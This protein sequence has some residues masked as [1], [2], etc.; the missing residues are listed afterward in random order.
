MGDKINRDILGARQAGFRLAV[1]IRHVYD[2][3]EPDEGAVPDAVITRMDELLPLLERELEKDRKMASALAAR[4]IK[5]LFFDAG[6]ILYQRA[7]PDAHFRIFLDAHPATPQKHF[8]EKSKALKELAFIGAL[9]RRQYHTRL[10]SLHG[11]EDPALVEEGIAALEQDELVVEIMPGVP[12]TLQTLKKC[13]FLLGIITDTALPNYIKLEWFR[14]AGFG[15]VWD[16]F[17]S[18]RESGV[19]KPAAS[20]YQRGL[21]QIG[22]PANQCVF[23]GHRD[24]ELEGARAMGMVTVAYNYDAEAKADF[25]IRD[26]A[27]LLRLPF[28]A[29]FELV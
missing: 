27:D 19:R 7:K 8:K 16:S 5:A 1:Q 11:I 3:G 23:V 26:F 28:I 24:Y 9:D 14:Q 22:V 25:Y 15:D 2:D 10:L 20:I 6:D 12:A 13:G 18:S 17:I 29:Q 21:D 4:P